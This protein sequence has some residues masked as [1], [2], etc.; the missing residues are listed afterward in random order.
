MPELGWDK[1]HFLSLVDS[2]NSLDRDLLA[3]RLDLLAQPERTWMEMYWLKNCSIRQLAHI[4]Q[5]S[6]SAMR[7]RIKRLAWRLMDGPYI[8][9]CRKRIRFNKQQLAIAYKHFIRGRGY[10]SIADE[11]SLPLWSVRS[12]LEE[13]CRWLD[14]QDK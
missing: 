14:E 11:T 8:R 6:E 7:R 2:D 10:R 13:M 1:H 3:R 9:L 12:T 5:I 4:E